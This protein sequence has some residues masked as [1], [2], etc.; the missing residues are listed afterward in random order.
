MQGKV[1]SVGSALLFF[2]RLLILSL[3]PEPTAAFG[4]DPGRDLFVT[5]LQPAPGEPVFGA[6]E[7]VVE[8]SPIDSV[9]T[10]DF[11]VDSNFAARRREPPFRV[12]VEVG[13]DNAEH[14]FEVV[15]RGAEATGRAL[16]VSPAYRVDGEIDLDLQQ[17]YVTITRDEQRVLDVRQEEIKVFDEGAAQR[18]VTFETGDV[19]LT[20]VLMIDASESMK[21]ERLSVA[22]RG[23]QAFIDG[24][25][26]LDLAKVL[27]FSDRVLLSTPFTGFQQ[28][29][30]AGLGSVEGTGGSAINDHLYL[31]LR[32]LEQRQGRRVLVLLSDGV[33]VASILDM[34]AVSSAARR[35]QTLVY[36]IRLGQPQKGTGF[37]T[38]WRDAKANRAEEK[39]L[40]QVV[41]RSGGRVE[42]I[43]TVEQTEG[44]FG[45]ILDELREQYV[46]GYYPSHRRGDG[47]W[48]QV[49]V[50][51]ERRGV[52]V[53][54]QEGY[55]D[56]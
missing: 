5:I 9:D 56:D 49:E 1:R 13:Q 24:M 10:V 2:L 54:T 21:G 23:A 29:L 22:L 40:H 34:A 4:K 7:L 51:V 52:N 30:T 53:R 42:T 38:A 39:L 35:A 18:L 26:P 44:A 33:E 16:L 41:A 46:L 3:L 15:A 20:A 45:R 47:S 50:R 37:Q 28:V 14:R 48:R 32:L 27:L 43:A 8:V 55:R 19:P 31:A 25:K 6:V 11:F 36:W 12:E 17:L